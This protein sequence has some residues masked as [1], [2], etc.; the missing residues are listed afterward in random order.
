VIVVDASAVIAALLDDGPARSALALEPAH[1]PHVVDAELAS[2]LRGLVRGGAV[3]GDEAVEVLARWRRTGIRRH[4]VVD[5]LDRLWELRENVTP[6]DACYVAL[7]ERLGCS[8]VTA[9]AR[10][11]RA[12][13]IRCRVIV[14][15]S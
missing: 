5:L 10:L 13:G 7:A 15:A 14:V 1:A 3:R 6:Y 11:S 4:P 12:P 9:D 8:L 2:G